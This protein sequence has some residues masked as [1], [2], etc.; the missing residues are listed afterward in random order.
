MAS[1]PSQRC[2][3]A[4]GFSSIQFLTVSLPAVWDKPQTTILKPSSYQDIAEG[5][6]LFC[7][8]VVLDRNPEDLATQLSNKIYEHA[9]SGKLG[10][11]AFPDFQTPIRQLHSGPQ[12]PEVGTF[13]VCRQHGQ[14]LVILE[15]LAS[16]FLEDESLKE[17]TVDIIMDHN[18]KYNPDGEFLAAAKRTVDVHML[19]IQIKIHK[20]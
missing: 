4:P 19:G 9:R 15:S 14:K 17:Q 20:C 6:S 3:T 8:S 11:P 18:T 1:F 16:P 12:R 10:L 13:Q 7:G 5:K 2:K